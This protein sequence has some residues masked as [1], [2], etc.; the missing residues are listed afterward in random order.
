VT[1]QG[2]GLGVGIDIGGGTF[3]GSIFRFDGQKKGSNVEY[4]HFF[5]Y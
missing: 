1:S 4:K 2:V 5:I 3:S